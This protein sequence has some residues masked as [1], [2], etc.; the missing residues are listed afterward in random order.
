M[1][2]LRVSIFNLSSEQSQFIAPVLVTGYLSVSKY[3]VPLLTK[4]AGPVSLYLR[5]FWIRAFEIL[6]IPVSP[7]RLP[8]ALLMVG[9]FSTWILTA[10]ASVA[11]NGAGHK[12]G[13]V[14]KEPRIHKHKLEGVYHRITSAH[15]ALI[16]FFPAFAV[17]T[18]LVQIYDSRGDLLNDV[19]LLT[20]MK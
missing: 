2:S 3:V 19:I 20:T 4:K 9:F 5:P 17:A 13:Y 14:N 10:S 6:S 1:A 18:A 11:A 16:E 15:S 8:V 7:E 12:D